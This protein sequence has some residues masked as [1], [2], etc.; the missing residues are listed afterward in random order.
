MRLKKCGDVAYIVEG[1]CAENAGGICDVE[2]G[3]PNGDEILLINGLSF[4]MQGGKRRVPMANFLA[5]ENDIKVFSDGKW[6]P[7]RGILNEGGRLVYSTRYIQENLITL[8]IDSVALAQKQEEL[9]QRIAKI[10]RL[11]SGEDFL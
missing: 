3:S 4:K 5:K 6:Y 1:L 7:V 10:E 9:E 8:L 11:I 2:W